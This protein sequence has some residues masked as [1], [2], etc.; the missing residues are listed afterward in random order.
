M[1]HTRLKSIFTKK[2]K[3]KELDIIFLPV[4][5]VSKRGRKEKDIPVRASA[6]VHKLSISR[7]EEK[8][9]AYR[10]EAIC[11]RPCLY[12]VYSA[13]YVCV[14]TILIHCDVALCCL[15]A[16]G[17]FKYSFE[18]FRLETIIAK[19][20]FMPIV[21]CTLKIVLRI[22]LSFLRIVSGISKINGKADEEKPDN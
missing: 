16:I 6:F 11:Q 12:L 9:V 1:M 18:E 20:G 14:Y 5:T 8:Y 4:Q 10:T 17:L 15:V 2:Q 19:D 3:T 13:L 22:P 7:R 21:K